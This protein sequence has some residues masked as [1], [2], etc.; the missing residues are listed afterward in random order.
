MAKRPFL[1][2]PDHSCV[3]LEGPYRVER[4]AYNWYVLGHHEVHACRSAADA[5]AA[6]T[7]LTRQLPA[8]RLAEQAL[9]DLPRDYEGPG[10]S[11]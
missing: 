2:L 1:V 6:C 7:R 10:S 3:P 8:H 4:H 5:A 11:A 9:A